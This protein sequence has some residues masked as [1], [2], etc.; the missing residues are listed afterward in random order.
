M[1]EGSLPA[2][3]VRAVGVCNRGCVSVTG[4]SCGWGRGGS[5]VCVYAKVCPRAYGV[6]QH[7]VTASGDCGPIPTWVPSQTQENL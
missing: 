4:C 2:T 1:R 7:V 3:D 5:A 6:A